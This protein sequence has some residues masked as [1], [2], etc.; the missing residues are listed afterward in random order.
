MSEDE[1]YAARVRESPVKLR[2]A[3][4]VTLPLPGLTVADL[5]ASPK[6]KRSFAA[7]KLSEDTFAISQTS[8]ESE[9]KGVMTASLQS[10][11]KK[12]DSESVEEKHVLF[13]SLPEQDS[14][15]ITFQPAYE[16]SPKSTSLHPE[17][18]T[19]KCNSIATDQGSSLKTVSMLSSHKTLGSKSSLAF[20]SKLDSNGL[21]RSIT[22][23]MASPE[24]SSTDEFRAYQYKIRNF[25]T[26]AVFR[27]STFFIPLSLRAENSPAKIFR[28][29]MNERIHVRMEEIVKPQGQL[30]RMRSNAIKNAS[31]LFRTSSGKSI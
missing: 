27:P 4:N 28:E 31:I 20:M 24:P 19:C 3:D 21:F 12:K 10:I 6:G 30:D 13:D 8:E 11:L 29:R 14:V 18:P 7:S 15:D 22:P 2:R 26:K 5:E 1:S 17:C 25:A 23:E 16:Q 9:I